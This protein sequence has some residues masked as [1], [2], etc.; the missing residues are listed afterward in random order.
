[1]NNFDILVKELMESVAG[2]MVS[3]GAGSSL[4]SPATPIGDTGGSFGNKDSW[5]TGSS[6]LAK[7]LGF[8]T[9][10]RKKPETINKLSRKNRK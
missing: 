6:L 10:T 2:A 7:P 1:M 8:K 3:G 4:G 5:N 9:Q